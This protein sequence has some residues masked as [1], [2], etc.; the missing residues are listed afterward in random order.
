MFVFWLTLIMG[1]LDQ[2]LDAITTAL[3]LSTL[4]G[5]QHAKKL[6]ECQTPL[7]FPHA[8]QLSF[9]CLAIASYFASV[10]NWLHFLSKF[11]TLFPEC[12]TSS[13]ISLELARI[14]WHFKRSSTKQVNPFEVP[15]QLWSWKMAP[16]CAKIFW[17]GIAP[18]RKCHV[19]LAIK[20]KS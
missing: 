20:N 7:H 9:T 17:M 5:C 6:A 12:W 11:K 18:A 4:P 14:L 2:T 8:S 19:K 16:S 15:F 10:F 13:L 1:D 3:Q